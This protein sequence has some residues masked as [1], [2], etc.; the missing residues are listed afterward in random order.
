MCLFKYVCCSVLELFLS[1][2]VLYC[3]SV[4]MFVWTPGRVA[5]AFATDN[6]DPNKIPNSKAPFTHSTSL[7]EM[8]EL[9]SSNK[10]FKG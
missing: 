5:A 7:S 10:L 4:E 1:I 9:Q 6:G 2:D 8:V 3:H